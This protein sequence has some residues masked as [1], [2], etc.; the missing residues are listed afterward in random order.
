MGCKYARFRVPKRNKCPS[1]VEMAADKRQT[2]QMSDRVTLSAVRG[3]KDA[4]LKG[5]RSRYFR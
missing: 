4:V 2:G 3:K 5:A 1:G